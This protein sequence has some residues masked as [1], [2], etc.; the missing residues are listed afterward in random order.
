MSTPLVI[1]Q[2]E[3]EA[4]LCRALTAC[5]ISYLNFISIIAL[6]DLAEQLGARLDIQDGTLETRYFRYDSDD[7]YIFTDPL[8]NI[9]SISTVDCE[10]NETVYNLCDFD[11]YDY[12]KGFLCRIKK[13]G[14]NSSC[15]DTCGASNSCLRW[16]IEASY[17]YP[18]SM[19]KMVT[20]LI[21]ELVRMNDCESQIKSYS[22]GD[23]SVTF[24]RDKRLVYEKFGS[25]YKSYI[26]GKQINVGT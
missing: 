23:Y 22:L 17:G 6:E 11:T 12:G 21:S 20:L 14:S 5:E 15:C 25:L 19:Q 10:G 8:T 18:A 13:C 4:L 3:V 1:D 9:V 26:C 2:A 16:K 7:T 24:E